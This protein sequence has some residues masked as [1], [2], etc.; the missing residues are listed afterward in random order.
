MTGFLGQ[1][2]DFTGED[3][4]WYA[5]VSDLPAL[6]INMR[7]TSPVPS[8]PEI[9]YITGLSLLT[10]DA[11]G[12]DHNILISVVEPHNM[13]SCCPAGVSPC[14]AEGSLR[15]VADGNEVLLAPG[16]VTLAPDVAISAVNLPGACRSFGFEKYWKLKQLEQTGKSRRLQDMQMQTMADWILGDV[17]ATNIEECT[18]Y[19]ADTA[20]AGDDENLFAHESEHASFQIMLPTTTIRLSHGRLHQV[21]VRDP[22]GQFDLPDHLAWQMNL[23]IEHSD[24][25]VH[26]TGV[27]GETQVPTLDANGTPIMHGMEAIRGAQEDCESDYLN[28]DT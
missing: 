25:G 27:L 18:E 15:V 11:S 4:S 3:D 20:A 1:T 26:A 14:L 13:N 28:I 23:A 16:I 17:T 12:L 22:T 8:L 10:T 9:T 19:V 24:L 5:L 21:A 2:F 7:V 6:H